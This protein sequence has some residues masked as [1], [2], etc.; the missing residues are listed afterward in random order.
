MYF[1][2]KL[3]RPGAQPAPQPAQAPAPRV[4]PG[5]VW[6]A[7]TAAPPQH[8]TFSL[9]PARPLATLAIF[10]KATFAQVFIFL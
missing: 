5:T 10:P 8:L 3:A 4:R 7:P 9:P 1:N 2:P 6:P